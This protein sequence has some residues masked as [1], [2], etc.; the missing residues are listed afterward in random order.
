MMIPLVN[1]LTESDS[2]T[3]KQMGLRYCEAMAYLLSNTK[4]QKAISTFLRNEEATLKF[5]T[6]LFKLCGVFPRPLS[7]PT[8]KTFVFMHDTEAMFDYFLNEFETK[9]KELAM[10][11][12]GVL[13]DFSVQ[14]LPWLE[15]KFFPKVL[16]LADSDRYITERVQSV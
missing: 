12:L 2:D 3:L 6:N 14:Y 7:L 16:G 13:K 8:I 1:Y 4:S 15:Q 5:L 9:D 11:T 10:F